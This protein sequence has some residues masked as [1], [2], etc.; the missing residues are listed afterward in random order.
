MAHGRVRVRACVR[1]R[2]PRCRAAPLLPAEKRQA[3]AARIRDKY[4]DRIPVSTECTT[5]C[6]ALPLPSTPIARMLSCC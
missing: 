5:A 2:P 1:R 3:E 6:G 4:P